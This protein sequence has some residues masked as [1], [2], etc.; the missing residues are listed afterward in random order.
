MVKGLQGVLDEHSPLKRG[1]C[2]VRPPGHHAKCSE[3]AGFCIFNNVAIAAKMARAEGKRV[4][5]FDWDIHHGDGTQEEFYED[6][7]VLFVSLHRC[8]KRT[9]YP[10]N[11]S[12]RAEFIGKGK[13]QY[14]NINIAWE[15]GLVVDEEVRTNNTRSDLGNHEYRTACDMFLMPVVE[16]FKPD[17]II[18]SCGFDGGIHDHLGWSNLTSM[19]YAYMT[20]RLIDICENVL[21][22]QEGGY[23]V[24]LM[25]QH[26]FGLVRALLHGNEDI[27]TFQ[28]EPTPT[29]LEMGISCFDDIKE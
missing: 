20:K 9:F 1:Y 27:S 4:C 7:Q 6:D 2:I 15:T 5:I 16:E 24:D 10:Y 12:M 14:K 21:V 13:G 23:N 22:V 18:V 25:G 29:D 3:A 8:D 26:A 11:E 19:C 28:L 17:L